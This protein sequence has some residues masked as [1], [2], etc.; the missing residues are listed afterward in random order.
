MA[1]SWYNVLNSIK[2]YVTS[3]W[4]GLFNGKQMHSFFYTLV[5]ISSTHSASKSQF[6][7]S[8]KLRLS[9]TILHG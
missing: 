8:Y 9:L 2:A 4:L 1:C 7:Y 3:R 5:N 6:G